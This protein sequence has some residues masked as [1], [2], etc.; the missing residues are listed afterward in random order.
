MSIPSIHIEGYRGIKKL[1][2]PQLA[3]V[4]L[5]VG[6]NSVGK[7]S[8]LEAIQ[9]YLYQGNT[10]LLLQ[11]LRERKE[12]TSR[13]WRP[14][15]DTDL[16]DPEL[17]DALQGIRN[18]FF[19]RAELTTQNKDNFSIFMDTTAERQPPDN[20]LIIRLRPTH[21]LTEQPAL[22]TID[23]PLEWSLEVSYGGI[24]LFSV[25]LI[26]LLE[27]PIFL[28]TS[29]LKST[30]K[31]TFVP[32][33]RFTAQER[34]LYWSGI[35]LTPAEDNVIQA[36]NIVVPGI[37]RLNLTE[38]SRLRDNIA[39][40]VFNGQRVTL[41]SLGDGVLRMFDLALAMVNSKNGTLLVDE[42]DSGLHYSVQVKMW[43]FLFTLA[44]ELQ[45]QIFATSHSQ[46]CVRAFQYVS[47]QFDHVT[48]QMTRL[49]KWG[50]E[51]VAIVINEELMAY[52][53][54]EDIEVR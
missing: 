5:I 32:L 23:E 27:R 50:D 11:S 22:F 25:P 8:L 19:G 30:Q 46:D 54:D 38:D 52:A 44:H 6:K 4:N 20:S 48:G 26:K 49:E 12:L 28:G 3:Q 9:L 43:E 45:V 17:I 18:L 39:L 2:I 35:T 21:E 31:L 51:M 13:G 47:N 41:E 53:L 14:S 24:T 15:S 29:R 34:S 33:T 37:T 7:T 10:T 16:P 1:T 42:I 36:L 40:A